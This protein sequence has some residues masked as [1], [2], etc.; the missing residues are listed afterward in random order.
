MGRQT[1]LQQ[2]LQDRLFY[3][4]DMGAFWQMRVRIRQFDV[5]ISSTG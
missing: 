1:T 4:P 5:D 2:S 3:A